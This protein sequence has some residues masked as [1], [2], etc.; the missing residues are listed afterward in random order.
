MRS[1][2]SGRAWPFLT[3][4]ATGGFTSTTKVSQLPLSNGNWTSE[5]SKPTS[6]CRHERHAFP[7]GNIL[8]THTCNKI[9][10]R[11]RR[12]GHRGN[13]NAH[14]IEMMATFTRPI[15]SGT[16]K[17]R[18]PTQKKYRRKSVN[19][20]RIARTVNHHNGGDTTTTTRFAN[21][22]RATKV[23]EWK[24]RMNSLQKVAKP[25]VFTRFHLFRCHSTF[26][27][28]QQQK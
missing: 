9:I 20:N 21:V 2:R 23:E 25:L 3:G 15:S 11:E 10:A 22:A 26:Q 4:Q 16:H 13:K 24:V 1:F 27:H 17:D 12:P 7:L 5:S 28:N 14:D 18:M 19:D 6:C 8:N